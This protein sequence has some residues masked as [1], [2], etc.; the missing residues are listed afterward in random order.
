[1]VERIALVVVVAVICALAYR[2]FARRHVQKASEAAL[3]DPLLCELKRG[4]PAILYFTTPMCIPCRTQQQPALQRLEAELGDGIQ[5]VR[6]DAT[7]N[8][9]AA[10]RW[11][12]FSV[13]TTFILDA[14]GTPREVNHGVAETDKLK[15]QLAALSV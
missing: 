6:V 11:R 14:N 10:E 8:A 12:V 5:I 2:V 9:E 1:M 7:Q 3:C 15:R 4:V 13:P